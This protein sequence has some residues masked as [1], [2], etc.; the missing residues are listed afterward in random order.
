MDVVESHIRTACPI[1]EGSV[2]VDASV[3]GNY[4]CRQYT[5]A[6]CVG[7]SFV[8]VKDP[9]DGNPYDDDYYAGLGAC[10]LYTS[11]SPRD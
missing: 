3:Y 10:L 7:C 9:F 6:R 11:P 1:C 4:S 8:F 2:T 5:L